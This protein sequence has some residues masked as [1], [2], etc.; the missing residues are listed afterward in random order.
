VLDPSSDLGI[1]G[2]RP[3]GPIDGGAARSEARTRACASER[4][5]VLERVQESSHGAV[6]AERVLSRMM[7]DSRVAADA[8]TP[9][10]E[11]SILRAAFV[12]AG[13]GASALDQ[14][15]AVTHVAPVSVARV[16]ASLGSAFSRKASTCSTS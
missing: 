16:A 9:G 5:E 1:N 4:S 14:M 12:G 2:A 10:R 11:W 13:N 6:P 3:L 8:L 15:G 7:L